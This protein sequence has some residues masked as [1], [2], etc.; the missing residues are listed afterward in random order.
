MIR[1][2]LVLAAIVLAVVFAAQNAD[3][4]NLSLLAWNMDASLA[5]IIVLCFTAGALVAAL[6]LSPGIYRSRSEQRKLSHRLAELESDSQ[7]RTDVQG[8][9]VSA[10][11]PSTTAASTASSS[12]DKSID[13]D[14]VVAPPPAVENSEARGSW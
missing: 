13:G 1:L 11:G 12:A 14:P 6:A 2:S 4:V 8:R 9:T 3:V 7:R 10:M 5:V